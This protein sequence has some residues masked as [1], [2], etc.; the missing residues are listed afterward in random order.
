MTEVPEQHQIHALWKRPWLRRTLEVSVFICALV[1]LH[2][3]Q[4]RTLVSG[5]AP[6]FEAQLLDGSPVSLRQYRGHPVLL[7]FWATWCPVCSLEQGSIQS[8]SH[9][10]PVLSVVLDESSVAEITQWMQEK[11]VDYPV[12]RDAD[13]AIAAEYGVNGVPA[14]LIIDAAGR[15]RF[16][17]VGYTSEWGLRTRLWWVG[18]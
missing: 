16:I 6:D 13:G 5:M 12:V 7:Q 1:I 8:I 3:Y 11:G 10:H 2:L 9:D 17:E 15:I 14:S 4:T 18:V